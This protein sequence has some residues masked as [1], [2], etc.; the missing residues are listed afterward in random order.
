MI[1]KDTKGAKK[2][3]W[4]TMVENIFYFIFFKPQRPQGV[5]GKS[6]INNIG[7]TQFLYFLEQQ[8]APKKTER[9]TRALYRLPR[10][11]RGA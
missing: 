1:S 4:G 5:I 2:Y 9:M 10:V 8:G 7:N 6:N 11:F 3:Y